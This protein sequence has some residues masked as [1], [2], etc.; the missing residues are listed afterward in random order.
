ML[1]L[2]VVALGLG[3]T[4]LG[5]SLLFGGE[6]DKDFDADADA[7]ADHD[8]DHD[9][10][11]GGAFDVV[12]GWL[13]FLSIR[14]WTFFL[15]FFGLTGATLTVFEL[16]ANQVMAGAI[17]GIVG[18]LAGMSIVLAMRRLR[19]NQPDSNIGGSDCIGETGKVMVAISRGKPGKIRL[20]L[21][22][23]TVELLAETEEEQVFDRKESVLVYGIK[24]NGR[25]IVTRT[26]EASR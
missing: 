12:L 8:H 24:E 15:A 20:E 17:A 5:A 22:G 13:P 23:R 26:E 18:Y 19:R 6:H 14:F 21:K 10:H 3:G 11:A 25:A 16:A 9:V 4:L 1:V 7:D 2:Y